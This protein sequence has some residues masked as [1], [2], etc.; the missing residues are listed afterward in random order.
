MDLFGPLS[1]WLKTFL[2]NNKD[3]T[4]SA[5]GHNK[6][7]EQVLRLVRS[8]V[9]FGYYGDTDEVKALLGPLLNLLD[10]RNDK[11]FPQ[12]DGRALTFFYKFVCKHTS[13]SWLPQKQQC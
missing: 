4:A 1:E 7:V 5:I 12:T 3:M 11:P 6:L 13:T 2:D 9:Q 10:G 8:L